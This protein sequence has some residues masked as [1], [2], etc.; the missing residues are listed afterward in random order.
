MAAERNEARA[1]LASID[2]LILDDDSARSE[3]NTYWK[4][5]EP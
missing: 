5:R 3:S 1:K 4:G 2:L